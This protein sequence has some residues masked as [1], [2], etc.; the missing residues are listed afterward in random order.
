MHVDK[1]PVATYDGAVEKN[2]S[3]PMKIIITGG[4]GFVGSNLAKLLLSSGHQIVAICRSEPQH[5]FDR[6]N[7]R[8]VAADTTGRGPWQKELADA[9]AVVNLAGATIFRRWTK[10]YK[11][12]YMTAVF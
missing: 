9:D 5:Q 2:G 6:E 7:Y 12:K 8:F 10:K 11:S 4:S 3:L 1:L